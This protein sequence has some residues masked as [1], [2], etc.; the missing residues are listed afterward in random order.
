MPPPLALWLWASHSREDCL[1]KTAPC[2]LGRNQA[3]FPNT[4]STGSIRRFS[5]FGLERATRVVDSPDPLNDRVDSANQIHGVG[6]SHQSQCIFPVGM[7]TGSWH[8]LEHGNVALDRILPLERLPGMR[9]GLWRKVS[10][11]WGLH[12]FVI[13]SPLVAEKSKKKMTILDLFKHL[14]APAPGVYLIVRK[15]SLV[16]PP[17]PL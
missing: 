8:G 10:L 1:P 2:R 4:A 9:A 17:L 7:R 5:F 3:E 16:F 15:F 14:V 13:V 11:K 12:G 6:H